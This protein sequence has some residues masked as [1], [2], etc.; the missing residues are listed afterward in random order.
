MKNKDLI[1]KENQITNEQLF[2][3]DEAA[4]PAKADDLGFKD[5]LHTTRW[6]RIKA[7]LF[8]HEFSYLIYAFLIPVILNYL[9]YLA[10]EIHPGRS[11]G[12][13]RAGGLERRLLN[14]PLPGPQLSGLTST[15]PDTVLSHLFS[16]VRVCGTTSCR[17][18]VAGLGTSRRAWLPGMGRGAVVDVAS[19]LSCRTPALR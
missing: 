14:W 18:G 9:I 10:M 3:I 17:S 8:P 16:Q 6:G 15:L 1:M 4:F 5:E 2:E 13:G 19:E 12:Q 7:R 11:R